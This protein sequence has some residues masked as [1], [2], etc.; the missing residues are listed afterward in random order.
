M[1]LTFSFSKNSN[2][3]EPNLSLVGT[4]KRM[5][6]HSFS[7]ELLM[8]IPSAIRNR[9]L[10]SFAYGGYQRTVEPHTCGVDTKGHQALRAYQISGGSESGEYVG[11]KLFHVSEMRSLTVL[12][13]Q[14]VGPRHGYK[15]GDR[16]FSVIHA[17]L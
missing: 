17:E 7:L 12:P 10:I 14:F 1:R 16:A 5:P 4:A 6:P 11:W 15:R 8:Q 13:Q 9:Q 2:N 3:R